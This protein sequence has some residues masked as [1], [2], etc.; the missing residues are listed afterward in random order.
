MAALSGSKSLRAEVQTYA[1]LL[2]HL[3]T[4]RRMTVL[5]YDEAAAAV[6]AGLRKLRIGRM[7]VKI[8][9]IVLASDAVLVTRNA[10]DFRSV[11]GLRIEDWSVET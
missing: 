3:Q 10:A 7:D 1:R 11:P 5:P 2:H 4:F 6:A 8:A 9:S